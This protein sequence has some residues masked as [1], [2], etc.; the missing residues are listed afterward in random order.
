M[1]KYLPT[2]TQIQSA[3][4]SKRINNVKARECSICGCG[5]FYEIYDNG[6]IAFD[7]NCECSSFYKAQR[8]HSFDA[9]LNTGSSIISDENRKE[10]FER[11]GVEFNDDGKVT[12]P[13][14]PIIQIKVALTELREAFVSLSYETSK[15][16]M[17]IEQLEKSLK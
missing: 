14:N 12:T 15:I 5:L 1:I 10:F 9:V 4:V 2:A 16:Q 3:A 8:P 6:Q 11:F 17:K 7:A 13:D